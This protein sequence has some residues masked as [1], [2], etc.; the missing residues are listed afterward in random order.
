MTKRSLRRKQWLED[1]DRL[2]RLFINDRLSF[3]RERKKRIRKAINS[4]RSEAGRNRLM[5]LQT[6]WDRVLQHACSEH[7]RFVLIQTLFWEQVNNR[8][9]PALKKYKKEMQE[10]F[11]HLEKLT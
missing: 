11:L 4:S 2:S 9:V 10:L 6:K 5:R 3:E 8:W 7:N 1:H